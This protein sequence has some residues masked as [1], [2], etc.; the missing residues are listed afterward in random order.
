VSS[1][2]P[3]TDS[4]SVA[5]GERHVN[6][7]LAALVDE[8]YLVDGEGRITAHNRGRAGESPLVGSRL[9][10]RLVSSD[11][12]PWLREKLL[13]LFDEALNSLDGVRWETQ[14][15]PAGERER[16]IEFSIG[17][18]DAVPNS[19]D[20]GR[21][22]APAP[23]PQSAD[24]QSAVR[25][26]ESPRYLV[27]LR[28][29]TLRDAE[30]KRCR[31]A[32]AELGEM[33]RQMEIQSVELH[34]ANVELR[35]AR[36]GWEA[37]N[38]AKSDFL[39]NMS[40]EIR[41]PMTAILGYAEMLMGE[42]GLDR[43]PQHRRVAIETIQR[44]GAH[45]LTVINDI[46]DL[47][48]IDAGKMTCENIDCSIFEIVD[49][50]IDL[51]KFRAKGKGLE[52]RGE[53]VGRLPARIHSDPTRLRQIL[54]NLVGNAIKFTETG[55]VTVRAALSESP[56]PELVFEV[57]DTGIGL[58]A[59]QAGQL[60]RPFMQAD[61]ST[62]RRFGGTG[63]GLSICKRLAQMLG[64]DINVTSEPGSG[65]T[66]RVSIDP[67]DVAGIERITAADAPRRADSHESTPAAAAAIPAVS[68]SRR[69]LE[70]RRILL[71][72]DGPDNQRLISFLLRKAGAEVTIVDNGRAAVDL[73]T[74]LERD[75]RPFDVLVT[76][77]QMPV[78][79]GYEATR[80][81]RSA[82]YVHPIVALTASA[83]KGDREKCLAA[84]CDDY[85][86][87]PIDK[88]RLI[89]TV[90]AAA[91]RTAAAP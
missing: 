57:V 62:T 61:T 18:F 5:S 20:P 86:V 87:K 51:L 22:I 54:L 2:L 14:L 47:S 6:G 75:G 30:E 13:A 46:L 8:A 45:L 12:E 91:E 85:A 40:H 11:E 60:F 70:S 36:A 32:L 90:A 21:A 17:R 31:E 9:S 65:S 29:F 4:S 16:S 63:L 67:G 58:S 33:Q 37:A 3:I 35:A 34:T 41:T 1:P 69:P 24:P 72:E 73:A 52:L 19:A 66:F 10:E 78:M 28:D 81:L 77:M 44:N 42:E 82:G 74:E 43:A 79:D 88:I 83:M 56:A 71:A 84:G 15:A 53:F 23:D 26:D 38:Q 27:V 59:E 7:L 68:A 50:V 49:D 25:S 64:G 55:G 76:D 80:A 39:A 48:K 89:A